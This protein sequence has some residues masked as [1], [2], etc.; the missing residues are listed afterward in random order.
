MKTQDY[1]PTL[2]TRFVQFSM[3]M[4]MALSLVVAVVSF[5]RG[6]EYSLLALV[7]F[8]TFAVTGLAVTLNRSEANVH[9]PLSD[10]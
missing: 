5:V 4:G 6:E 8:F 10:K 7:L 9:H 1:A 2:F 3:Y